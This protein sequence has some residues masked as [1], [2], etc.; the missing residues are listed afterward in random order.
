MNFFHDPVDGLRLAQNKHID[1]C[2]EKL[3]NDYGQPVH[4]IKIGTNF[5]TFIATNHIPFTRMKFPRLAKD[6]DYCYNL[7][8][9]VF[10]FEYQVFKGAFLEIANTELIHVE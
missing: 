4:I 2:F 9:K 3:K 8:S 7:L 10:K 5:M 6:Y 1:E